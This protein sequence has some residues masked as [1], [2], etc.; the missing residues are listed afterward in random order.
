MSKYTSR[1]ETVDGEIVAWIDRDGFQM[2]RQPHHPNALNNETWATEADALAWAEATI[3]D[4]AADEVKQAQ[5]QADQAAL[6]AQA[7]EDSS[8]LAEIYD[9]IKAIQ[10]K[11]G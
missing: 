6:L 7:K 4:I 1:I 5:Q 8:K 2:I 11:L 9:A 3:V 10:T